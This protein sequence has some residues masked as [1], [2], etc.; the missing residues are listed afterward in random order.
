MSEIK[1]PAILKMIEHNPDLLPR[2]CVKCTEDQRKRDE[3]RKPR[4][5]IKRKTNHS[6]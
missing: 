4:K 6:L 2:R 5:R 3:K 1:N